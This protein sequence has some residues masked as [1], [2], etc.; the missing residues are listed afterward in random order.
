MTDLCW[1]F[2]MFLKVFSLEADL[3]ILLRC[4]KRFRSV[5]K[6]VFLLSNLGVFLDALI[7]HVWETTSNVVNMGEFK[8]LETERHTSKVGL[9]GKSQGYDQMSAQY[10]YFQSFIKKL[11]FTHS[12]DF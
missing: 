7:W 8:S 6:N 5:P 9:D 12:V 11:S 1:Y 10:H 4:K 3:S 2:S